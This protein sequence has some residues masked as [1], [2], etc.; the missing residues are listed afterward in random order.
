MAS[1]ASPEVPTSTDHQPTSKNTN[2]ANL[3][4]HLFSSPVDFLTTLK[5]AIQTSDLTDPY[6]INQPDLLELASLN[7]NPK[8]RAAELIAA[9][10]YDQLKGMYDIEN[11]PDEGALTPERLATD[12]N[13]ASGNTASMIND[14]VKQN[15]DIAM[16]LSAAT[17]A[18][19]VASAVGAES[20]I[21]PV[22][23]VPAAG[24]TG[25][26]AGGFE[27][28]SLNSKQW[29]QAKATADQQTL[30]SWP[31]INK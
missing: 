20:F 1:N 13:L 8:Q 5:Q 11:N 23:T 2:A 29:V 27:A 15:Q 19:G 14:Q 4:Q 25:L 12:I 17:A 6:G 3:S 28:R 21:I 10:H 9:S 16:G 31:E 18:L 24:Y 22:L 30:A 26:L 7:K